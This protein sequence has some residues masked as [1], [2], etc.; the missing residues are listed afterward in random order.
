M[1]WELHD[2][3][4]QVGPL[5]EDHVVRMIAAGLP[6]QTVIRRTGES[7]WRSVRS[8]APFAIAI[9]QRAGYQAPPQGHSAPVHVPQPQQVVYRQAP[10]ESGSMTVVRIVGTSI[11]VI[12]LVGTIPGCVAG[13]P[14]GFCAA[15]VVMIFGWW[16]AD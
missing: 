7:E 1:A 8:H 9:G 3:T 6:A 16:L 2:G 12:G 5:E 14:L 11:F 15:A 13:G 4:Q 10:R